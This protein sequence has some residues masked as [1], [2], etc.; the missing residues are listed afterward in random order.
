MYAV[1]ESG[2]KQHRATP[3]EMIE[4]ERLP[5]LPGDKLALDQVFLIV[6]GDTVTV[7]QPLVP[8]AQIIATVVG[9]YRRRKVIYFHYAAKKRER[10]KRGH[11]QYFTRLRIEEI[12]A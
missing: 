9:E 10:K 4:V 6:D 12:R 5:V 11:R 2:G 8:G 3:G 1:L 7:G